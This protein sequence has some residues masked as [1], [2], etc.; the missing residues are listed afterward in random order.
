MAKSFTRLDRLLVERGMAISRERARALVMAAR[1]LVDDRQVTKAGQKVPVDCGLRLLGEDHPYA[2]RGGLKLERALEAFSLDV[3]DL[4]AMD[5]GASTGGFT[6]CLLQ[7]GARRVYAVDVGYGQLAWKLRQDPRV[8]VLE[9]RN[10]RYLTGDLV[11]EAVQLAV[12][13]VSFISL[14]LVIPAVLPFLQAG[15]KLVAL[16]KPQFEAG[17]EHVGKGGVVRD[18]EVRRRVC[19]DVEAFCESLGL[20]VRGVA[21][22]PITG[23]KG[24]EELLLAASLPSPSGDDC[25]AH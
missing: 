6:D 16:V 12:M 11:P 2:S 24:N 21:P 10:I 5:V 13:D 20:R 18:E 19:R 4:T 15:A 1:V 7:H 22:S 23:P 3:K 14:K 8:V 9:R 25:R 17:R